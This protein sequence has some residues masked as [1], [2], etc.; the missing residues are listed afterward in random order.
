MNWTA[1]III[2]LAVV[3][4]FAVKQMSFVSAAVACKHLLSGALVVDVRSP[5]EFN[6]DH[7][8][9]AVNIPLGELRADLPRRVPVKTRVV[10]ELPK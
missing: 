8:P 1:A 6:S 9:G 5:Q 7:V 2:G 3:A 4:F 10:F